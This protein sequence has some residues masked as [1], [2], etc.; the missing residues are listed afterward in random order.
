MSRKA[1]KRAVAI[2]GSQRALADGIAAY[3]GRKTFSQQTV[4]YWIKEDTAIEA[5]YWAA[6]EHVT[7]KQVTRNELRPDIFA[8]A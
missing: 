7:K 1:I 6:I 2:A 8:A 4:S 5:E 3:L